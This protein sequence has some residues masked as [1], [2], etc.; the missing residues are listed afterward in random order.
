M[1]KCL[2]LCLC[3]TLLMTG[4]GFK[5]EPVENEQNK[6]TD[7][8]TVTEKDNETNK[9]EPKEDGETDQPEADEETSKPSEEETQPS[10]TPKEDVTV[11]PEAPQEPIATPQEPVETPQEPQPEKPEE[12]PETPETQPE[13][14][15]TVVEQLSAAVQGL[16]LFGM[17]MLMDSQQI[18]DLYGGIGSD[19]YEE[20]AVI[21]NMISPGGDEVAIFKV[22]E[23]QMD[24]VKAGIA[25]RDEY[26][27]TEGGFYP[28]EQEMFDTSVTIEIGSYIV[29]I[30][31]RN[32]DEVSELVNQSLSA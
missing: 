19:Q 9:E 29:Y 18:S 23:G 21:K 27:K 6:V 7:Q 1:K 20:A 16:D 22:K 4:C 17:S 8:N 5:N 15:K 30:A 2:S 10:E 25:A 3:A 24:A 31:A 11:Q 13:E 32:V 26:G 14:E 28:M 12:T